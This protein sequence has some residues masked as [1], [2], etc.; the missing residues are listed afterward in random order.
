MKTIYFTRI[1]IQKHTIYVYFANK[2]SY[3]YVVPSCNDGRHLDIDRCR[4]VEKKFKVR[5]PELHEDYNCDVVF[6]EKV[7]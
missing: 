7:N 1:E 3:N 4:F 2:K 6:V 5:T